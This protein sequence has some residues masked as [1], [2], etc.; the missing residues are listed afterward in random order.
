MESVTS[1]TS[2][3]QRLSVEIVFWYRWLLWY[4]RDHQCQAGPV[5]IC[6]IRLICP[7]LQHNPSRSPKQNSNSAT[8]YDSQMILI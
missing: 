4:S 5:P 3:G 2:S 6:K 8:L 1:L 7:E